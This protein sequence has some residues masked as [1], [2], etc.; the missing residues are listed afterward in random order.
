MDT[1]VRNAER[2]APVSD[3]EIEIDG[4]ALVSVF[5]DR[6]KA[7]RVKHPNYDAYL[8]QFSDEFGLKLNPSPIIVRGDRPSTRG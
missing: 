4:I 3:R 6:I 2:S 1:D 5:D 7:L 8:S